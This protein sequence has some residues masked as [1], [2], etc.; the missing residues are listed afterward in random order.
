MPTNA[1]KATSPSSVDSDPRPWGPDPTVQQPA[2]QMW[3]EEAKE[4]FFASYKLF[5]WGDTCGWILKKW[6]WPR[7]QSAAS[8]E[9][10]ADVLPIFVS[11]GHVTTSVTADQVLQ[12]A[13]PFRIYWPYIK[14]SCDKYQQEFFLLKTTVIHWSPN[15]FARNNITVEC[16]FPTVTFVAFC[17]H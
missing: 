7:D 9:G 1:L 17:K 16:Y 5:H 4:L 6:T 14:K 11:S 8:P 2:L 3:A 12:P 10:L 15:R 13:H